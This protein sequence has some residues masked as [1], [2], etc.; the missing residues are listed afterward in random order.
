[1]A[2]DAPD[3]VSAGGST[4]GSVVPT[5]AAMAGLEA[6]CACA[7]HAQGLVLA[8]VFNGGGATPVDCSLRPRWP[9]LQSGELEVEDPYAAEP[10]ASVA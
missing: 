1:M 3:N 6:G 7:G 5:A 9:R 10:T 4:G 8:V 2:W